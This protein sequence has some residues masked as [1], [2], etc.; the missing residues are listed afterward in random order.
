MIEFSKALTSS[1]FKNDNVI[2]VTLVLIQGS[3]PQKLGAKMIVDNQGELFFG[4]V[5]GGKVE[6]NALR[7][8]KEMLVANDSP[9]VHM[10]TWNLQKDL[11]MSCG[12][13]C[14]LMFENFQSAPWRVVIFGAGHISQALVR[15]LQQTDAHIIVIDSRT[16]W[17]NKLPE[18][19]DHS[20]KKI[21]L[22]SMEDWTS[23][24]QESDFVVS[25]T[26]GHAYDHKVLSK[27][28]KRMIPRF[29]GVIGSDSKARKIGLG[30]REE[31]IPEEVVRVV[32]C[33]VGLP[34]SGNTPC[35]IAISIVAQLIQL[36]NNG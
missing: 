7:V 29:I 16:E 3:A 35:E 18:E 27:L 11:G 20:F 36:K 2:V 26:M 23:E 8:S 28:L 33:P 22:E 4:T 12:G 9:A 32:Q 31:N 5:G 19:T 14:T 34:I 24:V 15:I 30:L 13:K 25:M 17:L 1:L 6:L 10:I 21:H